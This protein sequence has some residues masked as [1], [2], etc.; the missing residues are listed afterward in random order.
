MCLQRYDLMAPKDSYEVADKRT[1]EIELTLKE[2]ARPV[3]N[4]RL[5]EKI[6][7]GLFR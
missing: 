3:E 5:G 6:A 4:A 7:I 2:F 1:I